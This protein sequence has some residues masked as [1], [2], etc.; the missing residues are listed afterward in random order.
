MRALAHQCIVAQEW[1]RPTVHVESTRVEHDARPRERDRSVSECQGR[2]DQEEF[3]AQRDTDEGPGEREQ[4]L[5][6]LAPTRT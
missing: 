5:C 3:P 2:C 6:F 1:G 4:N